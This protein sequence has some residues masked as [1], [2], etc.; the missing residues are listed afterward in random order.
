MEKRNKIYFVS[1]KNVLP[2]CD[3]F[4][5]NECETKH[6]IIVASTSWPNKPVCAKQWALMSVLICFV[7]KY[8]YFTSSKWFL[9]EITHGCGCSMTNFN[10]FN[11]FKATFSLMSSQNTLTFFNA[12]FDF[13]FD[14]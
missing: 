14:M 10:I 5:K 11:S 2:V 9:S 1:K 13:W 6:E 8:K 3:G 7:T 12:N 4:P